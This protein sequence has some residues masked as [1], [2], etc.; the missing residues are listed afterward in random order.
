M[1]ER[2][3]PQ[4]RR[5]IGVNLQDFKLLRDRSIADNLPVYGLASLAVGKRKV[6]N[7]SGSSA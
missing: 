1:P 3:I 4:L 2:A 5:S 6:A 7:C